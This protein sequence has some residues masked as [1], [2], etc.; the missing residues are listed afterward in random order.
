MQFQA[1]EFTPRTKE[2]YDY[3]CSL[4]TGPLAAEDSTTYGIVQ[5]SPLNLIEDFHVV[6][7]L[8]QDIMHV[9]FEGVVPY[10]LQLMLKHFVK[11][12][13]LTIS[14]LNEK[15]ESF[16]YSSHDASDRP[17]G[18]N[19]RIFTSPEAKMNQTGT[20]VPYKHNLFCIHYIAAQM[21][22]LSV[23][24]PVIIGSKIPEDN[25]EWECFL[26]L[27]D[28][29]K[30]CTSRKASTS[31]VGYLEVLIH[32]HHQQFLNCYPSARITPKMHYM[33]HFPRQILR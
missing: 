25:Q 5:S 32:T 17:S 20:Y 1:A 30:L 28:I 15:I 14:Q 24:L 19:P 13:Y 18:I 21:W 23:H 16:C 9:L 8:P 6:D 26:L 22:V 3:H 33:V 29:V 31:H 10:E 2:S 27:L 7:Q 4:L 12:K 11:E